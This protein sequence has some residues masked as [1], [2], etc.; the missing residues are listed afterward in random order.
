[1]ESLLTKRERQKSCSFH[2]LAL[3]IQKVIWIEGVRR[4]PLFL[5]EQHRCQIG[6][7]YN[8]LEIGI[9]I[10]TKIHKMKYDINCVCVLLDSSLSNDLWDCVASQL[11]VSVGDMRHAKR[12]YV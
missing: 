2:K 6:N 1:M 3:L 12:S 5:V 8:S 9:I 7:Y 10:N 4:L 11:D